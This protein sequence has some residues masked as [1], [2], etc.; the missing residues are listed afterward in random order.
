MLPPGAVHLPCKPTL[1]SNGLCFRGSHLG[2]DKGIAKVAKQLGVDYAEAC[3]SRLSFLLSLNDR[4]RSRPS[5]DRIRV[6]EAA[7][8][9]CLN[10]YRG[11]TRIGGL[12]ARGKFFLNDLVLQLNLLENLLPDISVT[13]TRLTGSPRPQLR[14]VL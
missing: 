12:G 3:V 8:Y 5:I 13:M 4:A 2:I 9:T 11:C 6:Q 7:C 10:G 1:L 14:S